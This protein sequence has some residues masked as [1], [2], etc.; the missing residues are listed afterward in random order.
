MVVNCLFQVINQEDLAAILPDVV[1]FDGFEDVSSG[2]GKS[3]AGATARQGPGTVGQ[4]SSSDMELLP[5]QEQIVSEAIKRID[6]DSEGQ[7]DEDDNRHQSSASGEDDQ[8][9]EVRN[10]LLYFIFTCNVYVRLEVR[11]LLK[12]ADMTGNCKKPI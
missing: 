10:H 4:E 11:P 12:L 8:H 7:A 9:D 3:K 2:E 5:E 1:G 6:L